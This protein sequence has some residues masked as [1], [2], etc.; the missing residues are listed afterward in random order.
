MKQ[1]LKFALSQCSHIYQFLLIKSNLRTRPIV[2][3]FC[4]GR[5]DKPGQS[6]VQACTGT[7]GPR[8]VIHKG[9]CKFSKTKDCRILFTWYNILQR[10]HF[11]CANPAISLQEAKMK[12]KCTAESK[13]ESNYC[14]ATW[15]Y[16]FDSGC[17]PAFLSANKLSPQHDQL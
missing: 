12:V 5:A 13:G 11:S 9:N 14:S 15:E 8:L 10:R 1:I 6:Q 16:R 2:I 7:E 17:E 3:D 4:F